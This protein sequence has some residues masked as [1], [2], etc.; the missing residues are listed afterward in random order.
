MDTPLERWH[1]VVQSRNPALLTQILAEDATFHSPVLFRPQQ[2]RD[3]V[4]LYLTGAM[5]VIANPTFRYVR[6]VTADNNA[7][8]EFETMID[9]VHVNGVDIITWDEHGLITDF[10]VMLR[11]LRALTTVQEHMAAL[12]QQMS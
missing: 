11:P 8:L 6:E 1:E 9:D 3:L 7:V 2:G 12:L 5:H 10:K 4:A